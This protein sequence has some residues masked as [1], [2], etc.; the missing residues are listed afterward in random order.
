MV[1]SGF[2]LRW[3]WCYGVAGFLV[4][5]WLIIVVFRFWTGV[6]CVAGAVDLCFIIVFGFLGCVSSCLCCCFFCC[7]VF[8]D[9]GLFPLRWFVNSV[10][11]LAFYL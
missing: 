5:D 11:Y 6:C 2:G 3:V 9:Y 1:L 10:V 7:F 4:L 8:G